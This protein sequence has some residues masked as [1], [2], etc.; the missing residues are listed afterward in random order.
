VAGNG[1]GPPGSQ[2][3]PPSTAS[4]S[5]SAIFRQG[6]GLTAWRADQ[7]AMALL[8]AALLAVVMVTYAS[9][10]FTMD[11]TQGFKRAI[12][13]IAFLSSA[14][15]NNRIAEFSIANYYGA[16]PDVLALLLQKL[17]PFL[18]YDA[19]HLVFALFGV[20]GILYVYKF[21]S[22]FVSPWTG[23][24]AALF[25]ATT[26][27]WFG[28]MFINHKDIP[29]AAML[30]A[31]SY[32]SLV[33]LTAPETPRLLW[34]KLGVTIGLLAT[35]KIIGLPILGF[36]VVVFLGCFMLFPS[37]HKVALNRAFVH[38]AAAMSAAA[39]GGILVCSL[40]FWPQLYLFRPDQVF[41]VVTTFL[42]FEKWRG[43]AL[44]FQ[45]AYKADKIPWYY[46]SVYF[47]ISTPLYL[48]ALAGA[49]LA[50]MIY[51]RAPAI[52][53]SA[54][55]FLFVFAEQ[56]IT[57]ARI[58]NG[59]R[60][61]LF[62]YPFFMLFAAYPAALMLDAIK[63]QAIRVALI[64]AIGLC[65]SATILEMYRLFP[66]QYSFYNSLVGGFAGA[67][68]KF[69]IDVWRSANREA[70][71]QIESLSPGEDKVRVFI[72]STE[73]NLWIHPRI[74]RVTRQEDADYI[75]ALNICRSDA[76]P[77]RCPI[78][79]DVLPAVGDVRREGVLLA[80]IYAGRPR[81]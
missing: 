70:L 65:V 5:F 78:D 31:S 55:I 38:R 1:K 8:T 37:D 51:K 9:Y 79:V 66:Y 44:I 25:L 47:L 28:Y 6:P 33:A 69:Y 29:F 40:L 62:V 50:C 12:R 58:Y 64:G 19:R 2:A 63:H 72:P 61:F 32:H 68:G 60:H 57:G 49:G 22:T 71:D 77:Q 4:P 73:I 27:M 81:G 39:L 14:G 56:A 42:N 53:A 41:R 54:I 17:V 10:G 43:T 3:K 21:G 35:I 34:L 80:R 45:T 26:P 23:G 16:A 52:I 18:S 15:N 20:V 24:F 48:L 74:E 75:V 59:C 76:R 11:E 67:D 30:V 36:V 7:I 13:V 46:A